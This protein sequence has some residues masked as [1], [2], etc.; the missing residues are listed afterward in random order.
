VILPQAETREHRRGDHIRRACF[1]DRGINRPP[2]FARIVDEPAKFFNSE[3]LAGAAA[4]RSSNQDEMTASIA[5]VRMVLMHNRSSS[6]APFV[7]VLPTSG[8]AKAVIE[9]PLAPLP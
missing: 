4:L 3:S 6:I 5:R 8:M 2:A 7:Q 1:L 9:K